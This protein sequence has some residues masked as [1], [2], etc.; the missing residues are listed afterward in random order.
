MESEEIKEAV[1]TA[2]REELGP[3]FVAREQHFLDHEFIKTF[4]GDVEAMRSVACKSTFVGTLSLIGG[5]TI[6]SLRH[7]V[8]EVLF[9]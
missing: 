6:W 1:R 5:F 2:I 3:L 4:R 8:K 7:W 9:K